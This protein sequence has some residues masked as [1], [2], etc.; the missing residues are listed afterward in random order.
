VPTS[1]GEEEGQGRESEGRGRAPPFVIP[2]YVPG[3]I[4][5]PAF[6]DVF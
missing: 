4:A 1:N 6:C 5:D 3:I 2:G